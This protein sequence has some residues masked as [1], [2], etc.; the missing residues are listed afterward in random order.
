[1]ISENHLELLGI[2]FIGIIV[3]SVA[4]VAALVILFPHI[5]LGRPSAALT[6]SRSSSTTFD[7]RYGTPA[8]NGAPSPDRR[9]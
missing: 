6:P 2:L 7:A 3:P 8:G 9:S 4:F 5:I 1:M